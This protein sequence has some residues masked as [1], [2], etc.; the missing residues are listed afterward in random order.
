[1]K[2]DIDENGLSELR[3]RILEENEYFDGEHDY[4]VKDLKLSYPEIG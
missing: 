1:M 3:D 4:T 2:L